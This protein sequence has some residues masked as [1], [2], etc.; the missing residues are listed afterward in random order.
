MRAAAHLN[1]L[2][3]NANVMLACLRVP[4]QIGASYSR[5]P[6]DNWH[7]ARFTSSEEFVRYLPI[8]QGQ[9]RGV[10]QKEVERLRLSALGFH[11]LFHH[12]RC[13]EVFVGSQP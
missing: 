3:L 7:Q 8:L 13:S 11:A 4:W 9:P 5:H 1:G 12:Y 10:Q 6:Y 2:Q